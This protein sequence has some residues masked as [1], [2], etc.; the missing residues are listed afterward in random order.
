[1]LTLFK[2]LFVAIAHVGVGCWLYQGR[3]QTRGHL[4]DTDFL[5]FGLPTLLALLAYAYII[6][7][8]VMRHLPAAPPTVASLSL[9]LI[10]TIISTAILLYVA[11]N[12][13]GT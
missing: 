11:F 13:Y 6:R 12:L 9:A 2:C 5:V 8:E 1:M 4:F 7:W 3:A 10:P